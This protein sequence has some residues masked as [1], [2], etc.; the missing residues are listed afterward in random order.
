MLLERA[1]AL[2]QNMTAHDAMYVALA[3]ALEVP[4]VTADGRLA[5]AARLHADIPVALLA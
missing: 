5:S 1:W 3:Q 4:L 2:R